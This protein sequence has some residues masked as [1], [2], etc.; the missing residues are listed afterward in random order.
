MLSHVS[1]GFSIFELEISYYGILMGIA[2]LV[3]ISIAVFNAKK[4]GMKGDDILLLA[5]YIIP[6]SILGARTYFCI[7]SGNTYTFWQ[8]FE[9]WNGGL[10][11]LGGVI[12]GVIAIRRRRAK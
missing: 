5:I 9:I 10:A 1:S 6:L 7:F 12:G 3:A 8:F 2:F 11:I 4:R